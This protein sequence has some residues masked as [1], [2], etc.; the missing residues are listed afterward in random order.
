MKANQL[1][2]AGFLVLFL[3]LVALGFCMV[4]AHWTSIWMDQEFT[5]WV[6]PIAN[7]LHAGS[8]LYGDGLHSPMPPLSFVLM[9][10]LYPSGAIWINES[11]L[12][13]VF[14]AGILLLLYGAFSKQ[15]GA[16]LAFVSTLAAIPVFFSLPKTILYDSMAQ[17]LVAAAA[18]LCA[19]VVREQAAGISPRIGWLRLAA[20]GLLLGVLML[21]KQSTGAGAVLGVCVALLLFPRSLVPWQRLR[22]VSVVIG[23]MAVGICLLALIFSSFINFPGLIRDVFLTGSEPKGGTWRMFGNILSYVRYVAIVTTVIAVVF[24]LL[25]LCVVRNL[26]LRKRFESFANIFISSSDARVAAIDSRFHPMMAALAASVFSFMILYS[27]TK[28]SGG[29]RM[30]EEIALLHVPTMLLN[31]GLLAA[32]LLAVSA[33]IRLPLGNSGERGHHPLAPYALIFLPAAVFHNLSVSQFRWTHDNNPLVLLALV[34]LLS[35]LVMPARTERVFGAKWAASVCLILFCSCL[36]LDWSLASQQFLTVTQCTQSWPEIG[37][38]AR[39]RLRPAS[40]GMRAL[41]GTVRSEV[42]QTNHETVL[43]LPEDPNV[44]AW[45]DRD[46]PALS[47]AILFTDQYWD[48]YVEK[49]FA[50]LE[51]HPPKVIIIGPRDFWRR[52]SVLWN[53]NYGVVRLI[54]LIQN[55]LLPQHYRLR[56]SQA[57]SFGGREEFM[58][59][60]VRRDK[61]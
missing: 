29:I 34:F 37:Y 9:R 56:S 18:V 42:N 45:F 36:I 24:L 26:T 17:F 48:R 1:R 13:F 53:T 8:R 30:A 58:D 54:D 32:A 11:M 5:G 33:L 20:L 21:T 31:V 3:M 25:S 55:K 12:N 22:N 57:I 44:E 27:L 46:R 43:L 40:D 35:P 28:S 50:E 41:V 38:L 10:L 49:D 7:R 4:P 23:F 14:Q 39:A 15:V 59:V 60:Y 2:R 47:S 16:T 51:A 19:W 61:P 52:F 6:G